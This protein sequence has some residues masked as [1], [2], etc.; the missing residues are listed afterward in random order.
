MIF[1]QCENAPDTL[2]V[3]FVVHQA[4]TRMHR[5]PS[6]QARVDWREASRLKRQAHYE[7]CLINRIFRRLN[8]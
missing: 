6:Y 5:G 3:D 2:E 4:C 7:L 1:L 8:S